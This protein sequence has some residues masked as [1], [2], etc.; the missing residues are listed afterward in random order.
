MLTLT[1]LSSFAVKHRG[2]EKRRQFGVTERLGFRKA[3]SPNQETPK[4]PREFIPPEK[5]LS[6]NKAIELPMDA[7][8]INTH[9]Y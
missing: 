6:D 1:A 9:R 2:G 4:V 8:A 5:W 3:E 7:S